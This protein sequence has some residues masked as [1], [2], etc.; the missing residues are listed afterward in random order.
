MHQRDA[1]SMDV[2]VQ[3]QAAATTLRLPNARRA[4][5]RHASGGLIFCER[6]GRARRLQHSA[7]SVAEYA[8]P[9]ARVAR[10]LCLLDVT[11]VQLYVSDSHSSQDHT[12]IPIP[13]QLPEPRSERSAGAQRDLASSRGVKVDARSRHSEADLTWTVS[14][15]KVSRAG[16]AERFAERAGL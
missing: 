6:R 7:P 14:G 9:A 16:E 12:D 5:P 1:S 3:R 11:L 4:L 8:E 13:L 10:L 2:E 15:L